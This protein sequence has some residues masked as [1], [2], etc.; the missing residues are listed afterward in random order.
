MKHRY[1]VASPPVPQTID[2][3]DEVSPEVV[4]VTARNAEGALNLGLAAMSVWRTHARE[5]GLPPR[6]GVSAEVAH[7]PH[8]VC[9]CTPEATCAECV[10]IIRQYDYMKGA[11]SP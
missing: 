4:T 11:T 6:V 8:G 9:L 5:K 7:C 2:G 3:I 10:A 1:I